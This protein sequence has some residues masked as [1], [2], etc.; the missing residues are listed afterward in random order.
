MAKRSVG[1]LYVLLAATAWSLGGLGV[2]LVSAHPLAIAGCRS[3]FAIP[4]LWAALYQQ[5]RQKGV[6]VRPLLKRPRLWGAAVSYAVMVVCFVVAAKLTTAANAILL[7]YTG[8]IYVAL[9]S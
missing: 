6:A 5:A 1:V 7:Q 8:P 2:K 4:V 9:L 3:A